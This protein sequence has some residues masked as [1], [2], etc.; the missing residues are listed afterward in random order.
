MTTITAA[1]GVTL[2]GVS[3]GSGAISARWGGV[4]LY[5]KATNTWLAMGAI[6]TVA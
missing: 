4:S 2:N 1:S 5:K 6:G 3:A